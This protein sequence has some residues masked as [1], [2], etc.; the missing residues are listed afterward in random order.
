MF[1]GNAAEVPTTCDWAPCILIGGS[2]INVSAQSWAEAVVL[3][4]NKL[5]EELSRIKV[6]PCQEVRRP[7]LAAPA[8]MVIRQNIVVSHGARHLETR[9]LCQKLCAPNYRKRG[10]S[11]VDLIQ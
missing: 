10:E 6:C 9:L 7:C 8:R 5:E 1:E 2:L 4:C 11:W 3:D